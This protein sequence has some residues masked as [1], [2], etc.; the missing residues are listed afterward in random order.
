MLSRLKVLMRSCSR[1]M[2]LS[3]LMVCLRL[4]IYASLARK[5]LSSSLCQWDCGWYLALARSGYDSSA[6][7]VGNRL[8]A[9]WAFFPL[10]PALTRLVQ[11]VTRATFPVAGI[12]GA[13]ASMWALAVVGGLYWSRTRSALEREGI[14]VAVVLIWPYGIYLNA[15]YTE[16]LYAVLT[17]LCLS[18]LERRKH[19]MFA[20]TS[21]LLTITR[22]TGFLPAAWFGYHR[23]VNWHRASSS[24]RKTA[25]IQ[26]FLAISGIIGF[27]AFLFWKT[28]DAL[29]FV[30]IQSSWG[31]NFGNPMAAISGAVQDTRPK[32]HHFGLAYE[33]GWAAIGL[34]GAVL[35]VHNRRF[36]EAWILAGTVG[37]AALS[38]SLWSMPRYV[39]AGPVFLLVVADMLACIR[40][41][42]VLVTVLIGLIIVQTIFIE[43]WFN[44]AQYLM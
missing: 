25:L 22:P 31:R 26:I 12:I 17:I 11:S 27:A 38:G 30:H 43:S 9:N 23:M 7:L 35:L 20:A 19:W 24:E 1:L 29:A 42:A 36:S 34:A 41:K 3:F 18:A 2:F 4:L 13:S 14:W 16:S 39:A 8:Q 6:H 44:G 32:G 10:F 33:A 15:P 40:R 28:G 37:L 21:M 5:S